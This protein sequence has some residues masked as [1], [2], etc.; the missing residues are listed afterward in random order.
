MEALISQL[1]TTSAD[2]FQLQKL[3]LKDWFYSVKA[4]RGTATWRGGPKMDAIEWFSKMWERAHQNPID[5][6]ELRDKYVNN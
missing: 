1:N 2:T 4:T 6:F 3:E 5:D